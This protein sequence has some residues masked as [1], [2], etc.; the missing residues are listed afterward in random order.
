MPTE[1]P[2]VLPDVVIGR[3]PDHGIVAALPAQSAAAQWFLERLDFQRIPGHPTLFA[4]TDQHRDPADRTAWAVKAF[5]GAGFRID[6]DLTLASPSTGRP[7][8]TRSGP[9]APPQ[10]P[11]HRPEP[12]AP[13]T[14]HPP[15]TVIGQAFAPHNSRTAAAARAK[16]LS[17]RPASATRAAAPMGPPPSA[18]DPRIAFARAR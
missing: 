8:L 7:A 15:R 6:T 4:L 11:G 16:S 10:R 14:N 18:V 17:A 13:V 1:V 3:H 12:A 9:P 5:H 2:H